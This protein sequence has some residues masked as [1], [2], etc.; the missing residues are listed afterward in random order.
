MSGNQVRL[1]NRQ[2]WTKEQFLN[3]YFTSTASGP[4][5]PV[6]GPPASVN[7]DKSWYMGEGPGRY[8]HPG[9]FPIIESV[10]DRRD[11]APGT[12]DLWQLAPNNKEDPSVKASISHY[13]RDV[14]SQDWRTR[15]FV[16]GN[17]SGRISGRVS[18]GQDGSKT[19]HA[20]EIRPLDTK[21][22]F[23]HNVESSARVCARSGKTDIRSG[24]PGCLVRHQ[25]SGARPG[26]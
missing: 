22:N 26:S 20:I 19:F 18:V 13:V 23:E 7:V 2:S 15:A 11:L 16:F 12:Y 21:C 10:I 24:K 1:T 17:E 5:T 6:A 3:H 9:M 25:L 14:K 4:R 8:Y